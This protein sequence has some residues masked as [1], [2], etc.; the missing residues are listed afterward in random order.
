MAKTILVAGATGRLGGKIVDA[1]LEQGAEVRAVVR[2]ES[3]LR[4]VGALREKGVEIFQAELRA[5]GEIA[6]ACA[7]ADC[8]VSALSGLREVVIDAQKTLLDGAVSGKVP[9]FIPSV[10]SLDFTNLTPGTNRNLDLR[11]EF[12]EYLKAAPI[13]STS[14]FNGAFMD[15]LT[16]DMPLILYRFRRILCWGDPSVKM[17][18]TTMDDAAEFTARAALDDDA[19]KVLRIAGD[20]VS[21]VDVKEIMS[22]ITGKD[23][24]VLRAGSINLLNIIIKIARFFAP[25]KDKLYPAWQ[26]MQY[27]R[28]MMEGRAVIN[29]HDNARYPEIRWT[30]VKDFLT[31]QNVGKFV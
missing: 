31:S 19:P 2:A 26:G 9:R 23:F 28:D 14:V 30:S 11:R 7:G 22:K 15:L 24:R 21:A 27:M 8:V 3:D 4:T 13:A 1:L 10:F 17:D 20:C 16:T 6:E 29:R 25:A 18:L 5:P 12:N